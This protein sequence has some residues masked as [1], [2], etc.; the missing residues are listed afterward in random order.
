MGNEHQVHVVAG[1]VAAL[2]NR[3]HRYV[4]LGEDIGRGSQHAATIGH[5]EADVVLRLQIFNGEDRQLVGAGAANDGLDAHLQ[6]AGNLKHITHNGACS[7]AGARTLAEE[8]ALARSIAHGVNGVEHAVHHG[9][10]V[11]FGNHSGM[12]AHIDARIGAVCMGQELHGIAHFV[13]HGKVHRGNTA[14]ALGVH[15][16][17]GDARIEGDGRQDG[18]FRRSVQAVDIGRGVGLGIALGLGFGQN[19]IV[20]HVVFVHAREHVVGGAV[21][22]AHDGVDAVGDKR[23]L[24]RVDDGNGAADACLERDFQAVG[25]GQAHDLFT[26]RSHKR[27]VGGNHGFAVLQRA[28]DNVLGDARA[29]DKLDNQVYLGVVDYL[30]EVGGEDALQAMRLGNIGPAGAHAH[31]FQID[32]EMTFEIAL[33]VLQDVKASATNRARSNQANLDR[34][35][36]SFPPNRG[37]DALALICISPLYKQKRSCPPSQRARAL[38]DHEQVP[39][40]RAVRLAEPAPSQTAT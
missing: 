2:G 32:A 30:V 35:T 18:D 34:H 24:Q 21:H 13:G 38:I 26:G 12:H 14:D 25:L 22:D 28:D 31:Q 10:L 23:M 40:W 36:H 27:L 11:L 7:R 16:V 15:L 39:N 5:D 20:G 29:A 3:L 8:H 19:L 4:V 33:V 1:S 17:H 37:I 9:Q 6:V